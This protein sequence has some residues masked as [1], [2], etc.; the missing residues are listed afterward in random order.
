MGELNK[1]FPVTFIIIIIVKQ[2]NTHETLNFTR[3]QL[4]WNIFM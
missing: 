1:N 4:F 2:Y 3:R